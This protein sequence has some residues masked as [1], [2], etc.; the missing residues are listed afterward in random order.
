MLALLLPGLLPQFVPRPAGSAPG[1]ARAS[2]ARRSA[3]VVCRGKKDAKWAKLLPADAPIA[4]GSVL[5][6]A[7]G[8][9]DHYFLESLVLLIDYDPDQGARGVLLVSAPAHAPVVAHFPALSIDASAIANTSGAGDS[10]VGGTAFGL[11]T[12]R[13]LAE[14]VRCG[15]AAARLTLQ[16][17]G[18]VAPELSPERLAACF[19]L[20]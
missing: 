10:Y 18:A 13:P 2:S 8:S 11:M 20:E 16:C 15:L 4:P 12:G 17:D 19:A 1:A 5:V 7:P 9:F 14:A 6:A 3:T